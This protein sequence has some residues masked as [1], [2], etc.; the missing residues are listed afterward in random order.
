M[1]IIRRLHT[2]THKYHQ[3]CSTGFRSK[4]G[5]LWVTNQRYSASDSE[6]RRLSKGKLKELKIIKKKE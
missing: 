1:T 5:Q 6:V 2:Y 4:I 3:K